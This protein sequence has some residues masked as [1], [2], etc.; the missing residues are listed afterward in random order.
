M[1]NIIMDE[2]GIKL[3]SVVG[4]KVSE[5]NMATAGAIMEAYTS[6]VLYCDQ[7]VTEDFIKSFEKRKAMLLMAIEENE[8]QADPVDIKC[9]FDDVINRIDG[10]IRNPFFSIFGV[11]TDDQ[12][13]RLITE[14]DF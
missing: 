12:F 1:F 3:G 13:K 14:E 10:A 9:Q 2:I 8:I 5:Y 6:E 7:R 11:S 4:Q